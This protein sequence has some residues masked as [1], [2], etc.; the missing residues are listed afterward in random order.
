MTRIWNRQWQMRGVG[1]DAGW[2]EKR[3]SPLGGKCAARSTTLRVEMTV[4][5]LWGR[6]LE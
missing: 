5:W 6:V 4:L 1:W 2:V 3:I